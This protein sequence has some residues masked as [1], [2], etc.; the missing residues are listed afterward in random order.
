MPIELKDVDALP[1]PK[2]AGQR[3]LPRVLYAL[4][5]DPGRKFG[6]MEEQ[7]VLFADAFRAE[8][9]LFLPLF[10]SDPARASFERLSATRRRCGVSRPSRFSTRN[11][12]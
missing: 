5:L 8:G 9:S 4:V 3:P 12:A 1:A 2:V 7:L 11:A 6:S 10:I